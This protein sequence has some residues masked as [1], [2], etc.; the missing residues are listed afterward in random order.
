MFAKPRVIK[1][2]VAREG[3]AMVAR[4]VAMIDHLY[5]EQWKEP[6]GHL[7]M[8]EAMP[9]TRDAV[10]QMMDAACEWLRTQGAPAARFGQT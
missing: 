4:V 1:P 9:G 10:K 3:G 5:Q 2:F 6:L 8:F 7:V